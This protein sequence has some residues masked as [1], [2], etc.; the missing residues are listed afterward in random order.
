[1]ISLIYDLWIISNVKRH[2]RY[3]RYMTIYQLFYRPHKQVIYMPILEVITKGHAQMFVR[4]HLFYYG[5]VEHNGLWVFCHVSSRI[6][7]EIQFL[8]E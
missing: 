1:M 5:I 2:M 8:T 3:L 6:Q 4:F 7:V